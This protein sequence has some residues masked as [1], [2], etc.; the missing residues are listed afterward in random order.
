MGILAVPLGYLVVWRHAKGDGCVCFSGGRAV[1]GRPPY[2]RE[3]EC[4]IILCGGND[5]KKED[6]NKES[7]MSDEENK[8]ILYT[9]DDGRSQVSLMSRDGRIG[10]N[11]KQMAELFAVSKPNVSMELIDPCIKFFRGKF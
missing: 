1:A 11:Q 7:S 9:T 4:G 3:D 10:L 8:I 2:R 6:Q 5:M